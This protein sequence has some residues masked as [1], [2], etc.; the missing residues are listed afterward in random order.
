MSNYSPETLPTDIWF[1]ILRHLDPA[2]S[3]SLALISKA[4]YNAIEGPRI[5]QTLRHDQKSRHNFLVLLERDLPPDYLYCPT[6][7]MLHRVELNTSRSRESSGSIARVPYGANLWSCVLEDEENEVSKFLGRGLYFF[8][9]R[10]ALRLFECKHPL[11]QRYLESLNSIEVSSKKPLEFVLREL[12]VGVPPGQDRLSLFLRMQHWFF[13]DSSKDSPSPASKVN[14]CHHNPARD[15]A[16]N[17]SVHP[18]FVHA[19]SNWYFWSYCR[20]CG[21]EICVHIFSIDNRPRL[22]FSSYLLPFSLSSQVS[23]RM[24]VVLTKW[25]NL[26]SVEAQTSCEWRKYTSNKSMT[27]L[28]ETKGAFEF[29]EGE[30]CARQ[31][32]GDGK[33]GEN[34][35]KPI[36]TKELERQVKEAM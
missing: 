24:P 19:R 29:F 18:K 36:W 32:K 25:M 10:M 11:A 5:L 28:N 22:T 34:V 26:G 4:I 2:A 1:A 3:A 14:I 16:E 23:R 12:R 20:Y 27:L 17:L 35:Y 15:Q 6:D 33:A 9:A 7:V 31:E 21:V 13:K 8:Q 30:D